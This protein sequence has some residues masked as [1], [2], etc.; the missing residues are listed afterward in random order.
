MENNYN[1]IPYDEEPIDIK[2]YFFKLL[3]FWYI[4]PITLAISLLISVIVIK[5]APPIYKVNATLLINDEQS[6]MDPNAILQNTVIPFSSTIDYKI[7]NQIEILNSY[8]LNQ[9]VIKNLNFSVSYYRDDRFKTTELYNNSPFVIRYDPG[10]VQP[11]GVV[12]NI[13][14]IDDE[15]IYLWAEAEKAGLYLF[16]EDIVIDKLQDFQINDTINIGRM[17]VSN[18]YKFMIEEITDI[19]KEL[20]YKFQFRSLE[21]LVAEFQSKSIENIKTSSLLQITYEGQNIKKSI[22]FLN[23]LI[24]VYLK[25]GV[26]KKNKIALNTINFI[27]SQIYDIADTLESAEKR[28]ENFRSSQ[29]VMNIDFHAQRAYENLEN[30]QNQ[31]AELLLKQKY[32]DY[33]HDYLSESKDFHDIIAPS[34]MG[35]NDQLLNTFI[36]ELTRLYAEKIEITVNTKKDNPY[37][38]SIKL[39]IENQ[40]NTLH[41]NVI[42]SSERAKI[43]VNDIDDRINKLTGEV[44]LL[45]ATQRRLFAY[46]REFQ[47]QDALYTFL[48]RKK[49]EMQIAKASNLPVNEVINYA[50]LQPKFPISPKKEL[51]LFI[52]IIIGLGVPAALILLYYYFNDKIIELNDVEKLTDFPIIGNILHN[53]ESS[54]LVVHEYP[55]TVMAESF[56]SLRAN[57]HYTLGELNNPVILVT[58]SIMGEGKSFVSVNLA[59]SFALYEKKVLLVSF[60]LR[61]P[62]ISKVL[63]QNN[64][65]GLSSYLWGGCDLNDIIKETEVPNLFIIPTG[66]IPPNP[67]ELIVSEKTQ[68][69]FD[70]LK[71]TFD[72]II[73]DTPPIGI[74]SD[75]LLLA[76][77]ADKNLLIVRHNYSKKKIITHLFANLEKKK[78]DN[79]NIVIND[80]NVKRQAYSYN[81][82]YS[83]NY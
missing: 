81:Y 24:E 56:R 47:L 41:E 73:V 6:L 67:S 44:Q 70:E 79:I 4:F 59:T 75:A 82:G 71:K 37:L 8:H 76:K 18:H 25:R 42:S 16:D 58:S 83:Y 46:E 1:I 29:K 26:E 13:R 38:E 80:V 63:N 17:Y 9:R 15:R 40:K 50:S 57:F 48:L 66:E 11:V 74:V 34:S 39:K 7:R 35:I 54:S 60:D 23:E 65:A 33:L 2:A 53:K 3:R 30:L 20:T 72:Y 68:Q 21:S 14:K 5:K 36:V 52:G 77:Y 62:T 61:R 64:K 32:Y 28:L 49:S 45:P 69:M 51:M 12:F 27:N 78:Y 10:H 31:K 22:D 43:S 55:R 19:E